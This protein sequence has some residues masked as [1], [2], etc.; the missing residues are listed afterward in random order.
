MKVLFVTSEI[1]PLIK[2][3][4]LA[5]VCGALPPAL[6]EHGIEVR[7]L[8]PGY[9]VV[10]R[11]LHDARALGELRDLFGGAGQ[12]IEG[13]LENRTTVLAIDVPHLF[14]RPGNPYLGP[15]RL[16]WP[17]NDLRFAALGWVGASLG[18]GDFG[19]WPADV[20]HAHD[21]QAA[22]APAYLALQ[23]GRRPA[24]VITIHNIAY[25]GLFPAERLE[26]LRLSL[27]SFGV[28]GVEYY[29]RIG[30]LKAG[31]YYADRITTVS[32]TYARE[33]QAP[34][35]GCGLEGLLARRSADLVGILNGIDDALWDPAT[36]RH[37]V[38]AY[39]PDDRAGKAT[40]KA[41][42]QERYG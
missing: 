1:Y 2:T 33:I 20:V 15:D 41:A 34:E 13:V 6:A 28:E 26:L 25:Q 14:N 27:E 38:A 4:G 29:G 18:R 7:C 39:G 10:L 16:D 23:G 30:F 19:A 31:L 11:G 5:D 17:D 12:L 35:Q 9:P 36:D 42:L 32:P 24:S 3:G 8:V 40:N 37:L 22:L 21:W